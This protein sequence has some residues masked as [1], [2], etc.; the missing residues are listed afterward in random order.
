MEKMDFK[1]TLKHLYQPPAK[2]VVRVDVPAMNF[3]MVDGKATPIHPSHLRIRS[4]LV[5]PV[6]HVEIHVQKGTDG[7]RL[8][9]LAAGRALVGHD[10]AAFADGDKSRWKWTSMI[11]QPDFVTREMVGSAMADVKKK[12]LPALSNVLF[13]PFPKAL[14]ADL[15]IGPCSEEGPTIQKVHRFIVGCG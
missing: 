10:M 12:K 13:E 1:K 4:G 6:V 14:R 3:L 2:E 8:W 5:C 7:H 15:H 9:G 11:M